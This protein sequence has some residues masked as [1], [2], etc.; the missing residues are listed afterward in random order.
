MG[1]ARRKPALPIAG[2]AVAWHLAFWMPRELA[3]QHGAWVQEI[4]RYILALY[5]HL[6][7]LSCSPR[8]RSYQRV[9]ATLQLL[10]NIYDVRDVKGTKPIAIRAQAPRYQMFRVKF[11]Y[12]LTPAYITFE[13][14]DEYFT[15]CVNIDLAWKVET[16]ASTNAEHSQSIQRLSEAVYLFSQAAEQQ[17]ERAE[18]GDSEPF[19]QAARAAF[20]QPYD[21]I[22]YQVWDDFFEAIFRKP[23]AEVDVEKLGKKFADFRG[24]AATVGQA[25]FITTPGCF[26]QEKSLKHRVGSET[27]SQSD[28]LNRVDALLPWLKA[29]EGFQSADESK[30]ADRTEPIEFT[31][32]TFLDHRVIYATALGGQ[33]SRFRNAQAPVTYMMLARN[34]AHWQLGR[35]VDRI[36]TL[37]TL[38]LAALYDLRSLINAGFGLRKID[39]RLDERV[40]VPLTEAQLGHSQIDRDTLRKAMRHLSRLSLQLTRAGLQASNTDKHA[41]IAG[42]LAHRVERSNY[43]RKQFE[44]VANELRDHRI[45]GFPRY[46]EA[47]NRRLGGVYELIEMIGSRFERLQEKV[48]LNTQQ[49]R[50]A[51][52]IVMQDAIRGQQVETNRQT[53]TITKVQQIAELGFFVL[54]APYYA[55]TMLLHAIERWR[56]TTIFPEID[57]SLWIGSVFAGVSAAA[58]L[59]LTR[60]FPLISAAKRL[61]LLL[62]LVAWAVIS[63]L[64]I[65]AMATG[66][67]AKKPSALLSPAP[68]ATTK[69]KNFSPFWIGTIRTNYKPADATVVRQFKMSGVH[70]PVKTK[71]RGARRRST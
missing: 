54:L 28:A 22:Y 5:H 23:Y 47:V 8:T 49:L 19:K 59:A 4:E 25:T 9:S 13:L 14:H 44:R 57:K 21:R 62:A 31:F 30:D 71:R 29:D 40:S 56:I 12:G 48:D 51:E 70:R 3:L 41:R 15:I 50:A 60:R 7:S 68:G 53:R 18:K 38:R 26:A 34:Q 11:V 52:S 27:F 36:H 55:Y 20:V 42:G 37:G 63:T 39:Q 61:L 17:Y 64:A 46:A 69:P 32:T 65:S 45:E 24:F 67:F 58:Y 1:G 2:P 43:Y 35:C 10:N 16:R 33:L 6:D 66:L